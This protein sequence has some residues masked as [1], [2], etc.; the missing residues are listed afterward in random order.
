[1]TLIKQSIWALII[2]A[3]L[4]LIGF[5]A[6]NAVCE[7]VDR[8]EAI[9]KARCETGNYPAGYCRNLTIKAENN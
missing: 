5:L 8:G 7:T 3:V 6:I 4:G 1:M 9:R 2:L